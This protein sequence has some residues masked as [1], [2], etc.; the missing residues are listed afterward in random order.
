[1]LKYTLIFALFV[2]LAS[3]SEDDLQAQLLK[4]E[5]KQNLDGAGQFQHEITVSNGIQVKAQ[6]NV[7]G[8]QGEYFLPG[9]D[10]KQ[11]RVTYTADATGF[12]P[13]VE[14]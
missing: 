10:G 1:M 2:A 4:S 6:G 13:K 14:E 11:I 5:N 12:H 9:E 8:I 3:C 7:N